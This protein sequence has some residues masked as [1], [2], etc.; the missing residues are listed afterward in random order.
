MPSVGELDF[1]FLKKS[2]PWRSKSEVVCSLETETQRGR[3]SV[4]RPIMVRWRDIFFLKVFEELF[5]I[6]FFFE[7]ISVT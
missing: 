3:P 4:A 1:I 5:F 6:L 2:L 7:E